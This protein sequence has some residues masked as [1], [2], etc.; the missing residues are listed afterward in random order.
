MMRDHP[1]AIKPRPLPSKTRLPAVYLHVLV[2]SDSAQLV[3]RQNVEAFTEYGPLD[4]DDSTVSRQ[5]EG[6][7][8]LTVTA[9]LAT[10]IG[11]TGKL[12][13]ELPT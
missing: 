5:A 11:Q 9:I 6:A 8:P 4:F 2:A 1:S 10:A 3:Q 13:Q 7:L 12:S